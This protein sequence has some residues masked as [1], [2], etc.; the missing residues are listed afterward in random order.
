[1]NLSKTRL[2]FPEKSGI[3]QSVSRGLPGRCK[4]RDRPSVIILRRTFSAIKIVELVEIRRASGVF[5]S[6]AYCPNPDSQD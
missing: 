3:F 4:I 2:D 6:G 1:M 5:Y